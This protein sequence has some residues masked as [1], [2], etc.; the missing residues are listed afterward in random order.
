MKKRGRPARRLYLVTQDDPTL[1]RYSTLRDALHD[2][3]TDL[4]Q[5][6]LNETLATPDTTANLSNSTSIGLTQAEQIPHP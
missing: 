3:L 2:T 4:A 6:I 5:V 1:H